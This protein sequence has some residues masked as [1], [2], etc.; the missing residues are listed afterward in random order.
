M[1]VDESP[2]TFGDLVVPFSPAQPVWSDDA[3]ANTQ[4]AVGH[5]TI[6]A[7]NVSVKVISFIPLN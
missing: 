3:S 2:A 6:F 5:L 4:T 1:L 7:E